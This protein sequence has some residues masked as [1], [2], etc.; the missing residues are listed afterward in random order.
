M[1]KTYDIDG[2]KVTASSES[3]A[4]G[5]AARDNFLG[6]LTSAVPVALIAGLVVIVLLTAIAGFRGFYILGKTFWLYPLVGI[7]AL[8]AFPI[9]K[10]FVRIAVVNILLGLAATVLIFFFGF[11]SVT[12]YYANSNMHFASIYSADFIQALPDGKAPSLYEKRNGKGKVLA[13][14]SVGQKVTVNGISFKKEEYNVTTADGVIGWVPRAA[15][16]ED[17]ADMLAININVDGFDSEDIAVD[18][19]VE[20]LMES[21]MDVKETGGGTYKGYEME[22]HKK[23]S[24][25]QNTLNRSVKVNAETPLMLVG[26]KAYKKGE[27][28]AASDAMVTLENILY[29]EDCTVVYLTVTDAKARDLYGEF[30]TTAWKKSL[31]VKDL[32]TGE[33]FPLLQ[34]DYK[35]AWKYEKVKDGY[36]SSIVFF[37]PPFK[38]RHFSLTHEAPALMPDGKSGYGGLLGLVASMTSGGSTAEYLDYNFPEIRVK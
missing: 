13:E 30:N 29:A 21:Y 1:E 11:K 9:V 32:D 38:S 18:R 27:Q 17:G 15:F 31:T 37:F 7:I 2:Q 6:G 36:Q 28:L 25:S 3:E 16:P 23:Y 10:G 35:P 19:E 4:R 8:A 33:T 26:H 22:K 14:L 20:R 5:I 12:A 24:I 34:A